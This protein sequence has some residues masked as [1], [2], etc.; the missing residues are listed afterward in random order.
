MIHHVC[1]NGMEQVTSAVELPSKGV[2]ITAMLIQVSLTN[3]MLIQQN[4]CKFMSFATANRLKMPN[5]N[6]V[7]EQMFCQYL[8][9]NGK[10]F[11]NF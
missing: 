2:P 5:Y 7:A 10:I 6:V 11:Y 1:Y 9:V 8:F 3:S 4:F